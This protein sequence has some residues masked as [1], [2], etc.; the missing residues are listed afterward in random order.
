MY[1]PTDE[2]RLPEYIGIITLLFSVNITKIKMS[3][4]KCDNFRNN[5]F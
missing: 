1:Q 3:D 5:V 2:E 4:V